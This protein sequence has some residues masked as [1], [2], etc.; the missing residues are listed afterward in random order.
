MSYKCEVR[1][2]LKCQ[3]KMKC[4]LHTYDPPFFFISSPCRT[5]PTSPTLFPQEL[6]LTT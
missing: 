1:F 5:I 3:G 6:D 4:P 2:T